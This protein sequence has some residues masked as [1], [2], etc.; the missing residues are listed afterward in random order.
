MHAHMHTHTRAHMPWLLSATHALPQH[1]LNTYQWGFA[2]A[3]AGHNYN[4]W[5]SFL[6]FLWGCRTMVARQLKWV[7][8][9]NMRRMID[10]L[11]RRTHCVSSL[12]HF[13]L[14][15]AVMFLQT[16]QRTCVLTPKSQSLTCPRVF[17]SILDGLTSVETNCPVELQDK[18]CVAIIYQSQHAAKAPLYSPRWSIFRLHRYVR[19][20]TTWR[21]R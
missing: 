4:K 2:V 7:E 13:S 12:L 8:E 5:F 16:N 6:F 17:T 9:L 18:H 14:S 21:C 1:L 15:F 19:P 10:R 20:L 3:D 11:T